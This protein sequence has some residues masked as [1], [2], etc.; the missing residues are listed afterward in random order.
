LSAAKT[1]SH[2]QNIE[3]EL[4]TGQD[5]RFRLK[6][7][8]SSLPVD[9]AVFEEA[10]QGLVQICFPETILDELGMQVIAAHMVEAGSSEQNVKRMKEVFPTIIV[11]RIAWLLARYTNTSKR[12]KKALSAVSAACRTLYKADVQSESA[13]DASSL[14]ETTLESDD[15]VSCEDESAPPQ[16]EEEKEKSRV[17]KPKRTAKPK[18]RKTPQSPIFTDKEQ[19]PEGDVME[20]SDSSRPAP[21]KQNKTMLSKDKKVSKSWRWDVNSKALTVKDISNIFR[22]TSDLFA[23]HALFI[24]KKELGESAT[25]ESIRQKIQSILVDMPNSE[26]AQWVES[27][28]RLNE[29]D[30]TMLVRVSPESAYDKSHISR[31]TPAP[32]S[33][34]QQ[35]PEVHNDEATAR[36]GDNFGASVGGLSSKNIYVED[37]SSIRVKPEVITGPPKTPIS[38][39]GVSKTPGDI[40]ANLSGFERLS[41]EDVLLV[42]YY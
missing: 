21:A 1:E 32:S 42:S 22:R 6:V 26:Y 7:V 18:C 41:N 5:Y 29:G 12:L 24:V 31:A 20:L 25:K 33:L 23:H 40:S 11:E 15:G 2:D 3:S 39:S 28:R 36:Q 37:Q 8:S 10:L 38:A 19:L 16:E 13:S 30:N 17:K 27:L 14:V 4:P 9:N 34:R 35:R